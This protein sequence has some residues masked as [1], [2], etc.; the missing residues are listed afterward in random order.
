MNSMPKSV[1]CYELDKGQ[2]FDPET[3]FTQSCFP[4]KKADGDERMYKI[5]TS[6]R[7]RAIHKYLITIIYL[8]YM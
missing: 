1:L 2:Y 3:S 6:F 4:N 7:M 8:N 5:L